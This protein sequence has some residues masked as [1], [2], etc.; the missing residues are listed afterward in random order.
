VGVLDALIDLGVT[1]D[2]VCGTSAGA[3]VGAAYVTGRLAAL[4]E[5]A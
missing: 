1:P 3:L 2:I 4:R 5:W